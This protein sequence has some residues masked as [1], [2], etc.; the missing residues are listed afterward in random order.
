MTALRGELGLPPPKGVVA[1]DGK[2]LRRGYEKGKAHMPPLMVSVWESETRLTIANTRAPGGSE[3][4]AT[5]ALLKGLSLKG[6][7][8][9]AD[10]LHC[11]PE[12]AREVLAAKAQY[13]LVLKG[14][15]GPLYAAAERGF[16]A[17]GDLAFFETREQ[18]M[19]AA[20]GGGHRS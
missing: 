19:A 6:C 11:H 18:R 14:N 16:A 10:A 2:T 15:H 12:M 8:V 13:A 1:I 3:V 20:N 4:K 7:T 5:L 9:T 17:A